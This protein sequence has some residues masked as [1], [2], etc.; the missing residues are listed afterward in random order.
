MQRGSR[1]GEAQAVG[2]SLE[3][4]VG[5]LKIAGRLL[6]WSWYWVPLVVVY[7][8]LWCLA[9]IGDKA[10]DGMNWINDVRWAP[11]KSPPNPGV[12]PSGGA[13]PAVG[14]TLCSR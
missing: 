6:L 8:S 12:H 9:W 1:Q 2:R 13:S 10:Y 7:S 14:N 4:I 3:T 5:R 11:Y